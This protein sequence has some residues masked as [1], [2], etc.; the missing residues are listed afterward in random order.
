MHYIIIF[1]INMHK[2]TDIEIR[3]IRNIMEDPDAG[4]GKLAERVGMST[5]ACWRKIEK[6]QELGIIQGFIA[7]VNWKKLG[8]ELEVSLRITLDKTQKDAFEAFL[9]GARKIREVNE[10]QTFLGRV[11]VRLN[12]LARDLDH[13]QSI[14]RNEILNLPYIAEVE[15]LMII[16]DVKRS[17]VLPI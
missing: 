11:D 3:L 10:I 5:T 2:L 7:D 1:E 6:F 12:I 14:Y 4:T 15:A 9:S 16:S 8:Y 13:Y 17:N